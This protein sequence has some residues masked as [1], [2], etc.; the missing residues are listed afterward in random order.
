MTHWILC[1]AQSPLLQA[2]SFILKT[3]VSLQFVQY[4]HINVKMFFK[5]PAQLYNFTQNL[6]S[7][8]NAAERQAKFMPWLSMLLI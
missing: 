5:T 2:H 3:L 4:S 7:I 1:G 6:L 8:T